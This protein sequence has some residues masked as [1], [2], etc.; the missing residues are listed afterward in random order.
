MHTL[1]RLAAGGV[2]LLLLG[3][4]SANQAGGGGSSAPLDVVRI[5]RDAG[6]FSAQCHVGPMD[7][8]C[9][10]MDLVNI[11]L[12]TPAEADTV[13]LFARVKLSDYI[14]GKDG[15]SVVMDYQPPKPPGE[16]IWPDLVPM[17]PGTVELEPRE[18]SATG[19]TTLE[20]SAQDVPARGIEYVVFLAVL[21]E[22][23]GSGADVVLEMTPGGSGS[24]G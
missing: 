7:A 12:K 18:S 10:V 22:I 15:A 19:S 20:W 13:D 2:S 16:L 17:D 4:G 6:E 14:T 11:E 3:C 23:E 24:S 5:E 1:L 21:P 9:D 8:V